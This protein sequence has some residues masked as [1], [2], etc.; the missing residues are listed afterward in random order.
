M[1]SHAVRVVQM[2]ARRPRRPKSFLREVG[3]GVVAWGMSIA[4]RNKRTVAE[5]KNI[6]RG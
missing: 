1:G 5:P 2:V 4:R 6:A 3:C